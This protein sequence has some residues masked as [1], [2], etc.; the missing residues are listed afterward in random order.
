MTQ[1]LEFRFPPD[2]GHLRILRK[3]V[4]EGTLDLGVTER[5]VD[6]LVLA[7]D[8]IV[9]NSIEHG[10]EYRQGGDQLLVRVELSGA[11][12]RIDFYDPAVPED[13]VAQMAEWLASS[14]VGLPDLESERGRGFFLM[15]SSLDEIQIQPAKDGGMH[16]LGRMTGVFD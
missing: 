2:P 9:S 1:P 7:M 10:Q 16:M 13:T 8:E 3:V 4:R 5:R 12:L 15:A 11:D 6:L 14:Q